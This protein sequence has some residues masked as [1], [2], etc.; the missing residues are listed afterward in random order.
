MFYGF[1]TDFID[2]NEFDVKGNVDEFSFYILYKIPKQN[3]SNITEEVLT[4][5][6]FTLNIFYDSKIFDHKNTNV[7]VRNS[8][9]NLVQSFSTS[10][11]VSID[12]FWSIYNYEEEKG[13]F[14]K[15][16]DYVVN[17]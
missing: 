17:V 2:I 5:E 9:Y 10:V 8:T 6:E 16:Y 4:E 14:S 3:D 11:L 12:A 13:I 1:K 7:P 15:I